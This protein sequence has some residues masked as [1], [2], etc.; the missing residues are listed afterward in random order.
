M[1]RQ[2]ILDYRGFRYLKVAVL[3]SGLSLLGYWLRLLLGGGAAYGGSGYGYLLGIL[4]AALVLLLLW[5]G[6]RLRLPP[7]HP[8][9]RQARRDSVDGDR[10]ADDAGNGAVLNRRKNPARETWRH[11]DLLQGWLSAHIYLGA[12][13]VIVVTLHTGF[14]L[15]WNIHSLAY[16]LLMLVTASGFYGLYAYFRYPYLITENLGD[17]SLEDILLRISELDELGRQRA[18]ALPGEVEAVVTAA[19]LG[20]RIGGGILQQLRSGSPEC[21][22]DFAV[23]RLEQLSK[24]IVSGD[25]PARMRDLYALLVQKQGL[26]SRARND[27]RYSAR[28][29]YWLYLHTPLSIALLAAIL[30]HVATIL[31]YW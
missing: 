7:S 22:T 5:Y 9:R 30:A 18:Q 8:E 6:V 20:T 29:R 15:G 24:E 19:R 23:Q 25:Q 10:P 13:L 14:R 21:P 1:R 11:G 16:A 31:L 3:L 2:S 28:M 27:I 17:D 12:A 4:S 26:V